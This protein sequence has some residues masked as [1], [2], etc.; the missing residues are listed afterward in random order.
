LPQTI[1]I[2]QA[3][4]P[5][6]G[7]GT[8]GFI[9]SLIA[10]LCG[11]ISIVGWILWFLGFVFSFVGVFRKPAGLAIAGLIISFIGLILLIIL[12]AV[13]MEIFNF[14]SGL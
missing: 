5:S 8:A 3:E 4:K 6:N 1:I 10:I 7:I 9:L 13:L 11:W 2:Q 12:S 14:F